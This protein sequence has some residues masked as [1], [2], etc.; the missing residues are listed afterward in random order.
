MIPIRLRREVILIEHESW[1]E[2][3]G[4]QG[5][6]RITLFY[7]SPAGR[8]GRESDPASSSLF[9]SPDFLRRLR[10]ENEFPRRLSRRRKSRAKM[11]KGARLRIQGLMRWKSRRVPHVPPGIRQLDRGNRPTFV[12]SCLW[13][14]R[15]MEMR[16]PAGQNMKENTVSLQNLEKVGHCATSRRKRFLGQTRGRVRVGKRRKKRNNEWKEADW[17]EGGK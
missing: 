14:M 15:C 7:I 17:N 3:S 4:T 10:S 5:K 16:G 9:P 6:S 1:L 13:N 12:P 2:N 8:S 11:W